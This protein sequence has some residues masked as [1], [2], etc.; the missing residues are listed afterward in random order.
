MSRRSLLERIHQ[1]TAGTRIPELPR[2]LPHFPVY[3]DPVSQFRSALEQVGGVFL[4]GGTEEALARSLQSVLEQT[5]GKEIYWESPALFEKHGISTELRNPHAWTEGS[6]VYSVHL[7][8]EV[9]FP[10]LLRAKPRE[11]SIL[12][13]M[14]ISATSAI[15][16]IAETGSVAHETGAGGRLL[17]MLAPAHICFLSRRDLLMNHAQFFERVRLGQ[18][19]SLLTLVTGPSRTAD[20]EKTLIVGVHGP[21][22]FFVIVTP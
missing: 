14:A 4:E 20:I 16:G 5:G 18:D 19:S 8:S 13:Q 1:A 17:P 21:K 12:D 22:Q 11:R 10:L 7:R 9:H 2:T 15:F 6:L 3:P